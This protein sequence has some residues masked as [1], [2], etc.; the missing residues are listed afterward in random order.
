LDVGEIGLVCGINLIGSR[1]RGRKGDGTSGS[2][3]V[4]REH[5]LSPSSIDVT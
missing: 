4:G 2:N 3:V 5:W 1:G